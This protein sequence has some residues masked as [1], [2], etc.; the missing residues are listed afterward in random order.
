MELAHHDPFGPVHDERTGIGHEREIADIDLLFLDISDP[1]GTCLLVLFEEHQTGLYL[2]GRCIR[3]TAL[4]AFPDRIFG[5]AERIADI[6][7]HR[8]LIE[9]V[10]GKNAFKSALK[11]RFLSF[12]LGDFPLDKV[13]IG[14]LLDLDEIGDFKNDGDPRELFPCVDNLSFFLWHLCSPR[15]RLPNIIS[16]ER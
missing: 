13:V 12:V 11:S 5:I 1:L 8:R 14:P 4:E 2:E 16:Q 10:N 9:I 15:Y 3:G 7:H 6:I